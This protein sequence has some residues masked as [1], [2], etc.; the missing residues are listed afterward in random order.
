MG[1]IQNKILICLVSLFLLA[2]CDKARIFEQNQNVGGAWAWEDARQFQVHIPDTAAVYNM[3]VNLR[4]DEQYRYSNCWLD[5]KTV[6]PAGDTTSSRIELKLAEADGR[7]LGEC[8]G[9]LCFNRVMVGSYRTFPE[10]GT[11]TFIIN[12]DMRDESLEHVWD[13]GIRIEKIQSAP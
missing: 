9:S 6:I 12:Q 11:Y 10:K 2:G 3:F 7:W 1:M 8:T 13:V 5:V 4:H